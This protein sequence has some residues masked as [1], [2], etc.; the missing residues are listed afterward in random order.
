[1]SPIEEADDIEQR[2][3]QE[4]DAI[5]EVVRVPKAHCL[6]APD[7]SG[8]RF[9]RPELRTVHILTSLVHPSRRF[10][11]CILTL[12]QIGPFVKVGRTHFPL[13]PGMLY[14]QPQ[15]SMAG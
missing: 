2:K 5:A 7:R 1:M 6:L 3:G 10:G 13:L 8:N 14:N 4:Q 12:G 9:H 11:H 15:A